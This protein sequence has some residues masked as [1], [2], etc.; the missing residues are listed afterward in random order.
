[1]TDGVCEL[2]HVIE[3]DD[4][5]GWD[6]DAPML[7]GE[8]G[9]K[10]FSRPRRRYKPFALRRRG[11]LRVPTR[12]RQGSASVRDRASGRVIARATAVHGERD[13]VR[14]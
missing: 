6:D 8:G 1:M 7:A 4:R 11:I 10:R 9:P 13:T 3:V 12:R 2:V 14:R 5:Q